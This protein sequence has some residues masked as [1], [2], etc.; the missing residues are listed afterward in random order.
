MRYKLVML[1]TSLA[2]NFADVMG[3]PFIKV[4]DIL[5]YDNIHY[6]VKH[7]INHVREYKK[8]ANHDEDEFTEL[9]VIDFPLI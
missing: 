9:R 5:F 3:S 6:Q 4:G 7:V 8:N 2:E 1:G